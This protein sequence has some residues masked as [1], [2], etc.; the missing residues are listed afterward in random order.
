MTRTRAQAS[1]DA[2]LRRLTRVNH[3]LTAAAAIGA[4]V[5]T[6]VIAHTASAH[7]RTI[8][9]TSGTLIPTGATGRHGTS[10]Q[11]TEGSETTE[12][13]SGS[14]APT[15]VTARHTSTPTRVKAATSTHAAST[16]HSAAAAPR[17]STASTPNS[18]SAV[19][20]QSAPVVVVSGGS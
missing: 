1:R 8:T 18:S 10:A 3:G 7:T 5:L 12:S 17:S 2:A 11:T 19:T 15:A 20:Q 9:S 14:S 4:G 16:S 6:E 13:L